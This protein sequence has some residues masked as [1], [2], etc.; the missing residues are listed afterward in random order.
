MSCIERRSTITSNFYNNQSSFT[1]CSETVDS[2]VVVTVAQ[3][4][5]P[6]NRRMRSQ[7]Q[8]QTVTETFREKNTIIIMIVLVWD[9]HLFMQMIKLIKREIIFHGVCM[10][11]KK[12]GFLL[13]VCPTIVTICII[14]LS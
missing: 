3:T 8:T 10:W 7:S 9:L 12:L 5:C 6:I 1:G 2:S 13:G 11:K 4:C 14:S